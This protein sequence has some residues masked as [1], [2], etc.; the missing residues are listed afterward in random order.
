MR[1]GHVKEYG[2]LAQSVLDEK[3]GDVFAVFTNSIY[4]R[5]SDKICCLGT[6]SLV[7]GPLN[8]GTDLPHIHGLA[9]GDPWVHSNNAITL[10]SGY[11]LSTDTAACVKNRQRY[12]ADKSNKITLLNL[13]CCISTME[14]ILSSHS[15]N[16]ISNKHN[17]TT[18][19]LAQKQLQ[20]CSSLLKRA[21]QQPVLSAG[22]EDSLTSAIGIIGCGDG[23]TPAG[24]DILVGILTTLHHFNTNSYQSHIS[25]WVKS[26]APDRTNRISLAHLM[27]ACDGQ[28]V[29]PV[30]NVLELI[31]LMDVPDESKQT[32]LS[33]SA[34]KLA[35]Y[36]Q[37]SGYYTL[38]GILM[39]LNTM[40]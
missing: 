24:D 8:I 12:S 13:P 7:T 34:S 33:T 37:S 39:A 31:S 19:E 27:A 22:F 4:L 10:G 32:L 6:A 40:L 29:D 3:H 18:S 16:I 5:S 17:N 35:G 9:I 26:Y 30:H 23:L 28:A 11:R 25:Q 36:G 14:Q 2:L 1:T 38:T 15:P 20:H 21:L